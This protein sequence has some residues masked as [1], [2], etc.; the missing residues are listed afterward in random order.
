MATHTFTILDGAT[1][2]ELERRGAPF[3]QPEWSALALYE[4]PEAVA[5]IH[6]DY[7]AAGA[8]VITTNSYA[9]VPFHLGE[10][11]FIQDARKLA[12]LSGELAVAA[13]G[14]DS[15]A[16]VAGCLPP[17]FGSYRPELFDVKRAPQIL[18]PLLEGLSPHIDLWLAETVSSLEEAQFLQAQLFADE[19]PLWL[20]FT[21][22]DAS[23]VEPRLRSGKSVRAAVN[24]VLDGGPV[25]AI[26][27]NCSQPEVMEAAVA[28]AR[29]CVSERDLDVQL[30][31]YAN[32]FADD[33]SKEQA[34]AS[35]QTVRA[36]LDVE[37]YLGY[38]QRWADAGATILGGCCGIGPEHIRAL[39]AHFKR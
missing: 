34:N 38:A 33:E 1:G 4:A 37:R 20:S 25:A 2:R 7:L 13:R 26:L 36:D 28:T 6:R 39:A 11:R 8:R 21:L 18:Q 15:Q 24:A 16:L 30:G 12:K 35:L 29:S 22:E 3:R 10:Q 5:A 14:G 17:L 27:F 32:A 31:V 23:S 19:R 9:L